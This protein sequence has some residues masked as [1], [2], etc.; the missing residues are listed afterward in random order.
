MLARAKSKAEVRGLS[1]LEIV[2]NLF[3]VRAHYHL[4]IQLTLL[5][6]C[7]LCIRQVLAGGIETIANTLSYSVYLISL[8]KPV[9]DKLL[10]EI[11]AFGRQRYVHGVHPNTILHPLHAGM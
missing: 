7:H 11:D 6:R 5:S 10:E 2:A 8:H 4:V 9:Q 3:E 1:E